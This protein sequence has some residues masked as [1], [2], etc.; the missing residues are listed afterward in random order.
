MTTP[1]TLT[2][3]LAFPLTA[4][5]DR[6]ELDLPAFADGVE[7]H[8]AHDAGAVF[9]GCGTGEF[10]ALSQDERAQLLLRGREVVAGRVPV[11]VGVG[12]SAADARAGVAA[13]AE[14]RRRRRAA[15]AAVPRLGPA[16]GTARLRPLRGR[17][18]VGAGRG[19]QPRH[20]RVHPAVGG[21]P[22]R[23][24]LGDRPQG[25]L[26]LDR[27]DDPHRHEHPC[28]GHRGGARLPVLQRHAD[29]RGVGPRLR[30]HRRRALLLGG[31]LLRAGDRH[32]VLPRPARRR[33]RH[34]AAT[35]VAA[36]TCRWSR[37]ATRRPA[38]RC[39]WSRPRHGCVGS[40]S[41]GCVRP[42]WS[43]PPTSSTGCRRSSRTASP[44]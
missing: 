8:L 34:P 15:D 5:D 23:H 31:A 20:G 27:A 40:V 38:S 12:G 44:R 26:R 19:L 2:G 17:R 13:A 14:A 21:L 32:G 7:Q 1:D 9:I 29:R 36:S 11:W 25:R 10:S 30:R 37:C 4:F 3:L 43:P 22:A 6:L 16:G 28:R 18:H 24:P 39:R 42:S 41:A 33:R 35:A